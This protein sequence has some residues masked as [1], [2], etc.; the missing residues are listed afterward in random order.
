M[1]VITV[2]LLK[3]IVGVNGGLGEVITVTLVKEKQF[4]LRKCE[5]A[6]GGVFYRD[7]SYKLR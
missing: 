4:P 6:I 3:F 7:F 1:L 2:K 5:T